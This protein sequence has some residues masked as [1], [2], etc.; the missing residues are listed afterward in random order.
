VA[1][2]GLNGTWLGTSLYWSG[3][4]HVN[5]I[6]HVVA[7]DRRACGTLTITPSDPLMAGIPGTHS[8][9]MAVAC[10]PAGHLLQQGGILITKPS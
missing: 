1:P 5:V 4:A 6:L 7:R 9:L 2:D 8:I 3:R 10:L